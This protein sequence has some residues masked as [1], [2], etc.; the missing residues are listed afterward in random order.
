M[1]LLI[2]SLVLLSPNN[3]KE[4]EQ[5]LS[6]NYLYLPYQTTYIRLKTT[7]DHIHPAPNLTGWCFRFSWCFLN[8]IFRSLSPSSILS[9]RKWTKPHELGH[10]VTQ[11]WNLDLSSHLLSSKIRCFSEF[12]FWLL[13]TISISNLKS[14]DQLFGS[15]S[16]HWSRRKT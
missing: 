4:R 14:E 11:C 1:G 6:S 12:P 15:F 3:E 13:G 10:L 9:E 7:Y 2:T 16:I 8:I 5:K